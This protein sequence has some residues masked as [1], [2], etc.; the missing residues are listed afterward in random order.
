[1]A[2]LHS[3]FVTTRI[4]TMYKSLL[5]KYTSHRGIYISMSAKHFAAPPGGSGKKTF[6]NEKPHLNIGTIGHLDHGKTTLTAAI[7]Q[8]LSKSNLAEPKECKYLDHL[9]EEKKRGITISLN[10]VEYQT[11]ARHYVH[12]DCP[13]HVDYIKNVITGASRMDGAILVVSAMD[14]TMPQTR[15]HILLSKQLGLKKIVVFINK[16][17]EADKEMQ[18]LVEMEVRELLDE[19]GFDGQNTPVIIGSALKA[20][21]S[22]DS[23]IGEK[24]IIELL[25][26]VDTYIDQPK[27]DLESP[28][29]LAIDKIYNIPG[30]GTFI[31]GNVE[32][33]VLKKGDDL[34]VIG[35]DKKMNV[36]VTGLETFKKTLDIAE[37]GGHA[38]ILVKGIKMEDVKGGMALAK[39]GS[40]NMFNRF[41]AH[42]YLL[43]KQ[44]GPTKP[45]LPSQ[46][47]C[48]C[49]KWERPAVVEIPDTETNLSNGEGKIIF[50]LDKK[51]VFENNQ[52][53]TIRINGA[54]LGYGVVSQILSNIDPEDLI[55][56]RKSI[57]KA[58]QKAQEEAEY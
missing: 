49:N 6:S 4:S 22:K 3:L 26:A 45:I 9:P 58:K 29:L 10:F 18:E 15:E 14:G 25:S 21:E 38:D 44:G 46:V 37:A 50:N 36:N 1:M 48:Y 41:E 32:R 20:Y 42:V 47:L 23:E 17:D 19:F 40:I 52:H 39:P 12:V 7:T 43:P 33:G 57:K 34:E 5:L 31:S 28:F 51:M 11:E 35:H 2:A 27:R 53:F 55:A 13:G 8:V 56:L 54:T 30:R 24:K 16:A